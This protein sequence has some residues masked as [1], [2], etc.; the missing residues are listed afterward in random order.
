MGNISQLEAHVHHLYDLL[1]PNREDWAD[2][3][4]RYHVFVVADYATT[5]AIRFGANQDLS[6]AAGMLHDIADA[7]MSR[8]DPLHEEISLQI[9]RDLM[10]E[11]GFSQKDIAVVVDDGIRFHSSHTSQWPHSLEGK[12][13]STADALAH[14]KTDFYIHASWGQ[15]RGKT[16][17]YEENKQWTLTRLERDLNAKIFFDDV[18]EEVRPEYEL[19]KTIY[20]R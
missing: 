7:R 19:L 15:G 18:R 12:I 14:L 16:K 3:L 8:F 11:C 13:L 20:S 2:W 4:A 1:D 6:R 17:S 9:S 5:L 10:K